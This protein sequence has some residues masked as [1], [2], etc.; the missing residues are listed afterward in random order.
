MADRW[1]PV[2]N[3]GSDEFCKP[4][5]YATLQESLKIERF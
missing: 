5:V 2:I 3:L 4:T 1:G